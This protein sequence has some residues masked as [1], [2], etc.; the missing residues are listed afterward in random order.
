[1]RFVLAISAL[2]LSGILLILGIGQATFLAGPRQ[3]AYE[4]PFDSPSGLAVIRADQLD[5]VNGQA[6][7]V[8]RGAGAFAAVAQDRDVNAW[9]APFA[10]AEI[11][12][13]VKGK[14]LTSS[15]T[16]RDD[17]AASDYLS[18]TSAD[19]EAAGEAAAPDPAKLDALTPP[20]AYGSDLW[21]EQRGAAPAGG[22]TSEADG[23]TQPA[24]ADT[25][26]TNGDG[27][28]LVRLPVSLQSGQSVLVSHDAESDATVSVEWVQDRRTPLAGPFMVSGGVLALVGVILYLLAVDHDRRALGPRRGRRGPLLG[29]RNIFAAPHPAPSGAAVGEVSVPSVPPRH[30]ALAAAA[31]SPSPRSPSP[32]SSRSPAVRRTIGRRHPRSRRSSSTRPRKARSRRPCQSRRAR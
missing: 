4:V 7:V 28:Q 1:M 23:A 14:Q 25:N 8:V 2:V 18:L 11:G 6:N 17:K 3:I 16:A 12:V 19:G 29:I 24:P 13:D 31:S 26:G 15:Q 5:D 27:A 30:R 32:A 10:H 21:L 9:V 22:Q 20:K